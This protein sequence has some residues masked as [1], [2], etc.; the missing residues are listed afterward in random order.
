MEKLG[1]NNVL[2]RIGEI[3]GLPLNYQYLKILYSLESVEK[4]EIEIVKMASINIYQSNNCQLFRHH[5]PISKILDLSTLKN[6]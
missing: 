3:E 5:K 6:L 1:V 4:G 2:N